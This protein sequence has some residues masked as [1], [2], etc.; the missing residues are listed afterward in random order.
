MHKDPE[1]RKAPTKYKSPFPMNKPWEQKADVSGPSEN[2]KLT[3]GS[4]F[5]PKNPTNRKTTHVK[6][7][8][9]DH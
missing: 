3:K 1:G 8:K 9:T 6:V 7:N 4:D 2:M 5:N